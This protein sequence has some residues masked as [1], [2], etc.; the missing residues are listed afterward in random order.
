MWDLTDPFMPRAGGLMPFFIHWRSEA[1][2]ASA[3]PAL[4]SLAELRGEHPDAATV[5]A[6]LRAIGV[7]LEVAPGSA[8]TLFAVLHTPRGS[9]TLS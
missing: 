5:R 1:H 7:E 3:G 9:V 8:P 6:Q 4:V 2:P